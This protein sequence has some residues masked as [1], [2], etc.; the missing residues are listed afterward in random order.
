VSEAK[1]TPASAEGL[2]PPRYQR[3]AW[4]L[5]VYFIPQFLINAF[6]FRSFFI[7]EVTVFPSGLFQPFYRYIPDISLGAAGDSFSILGLCVYLIHLVLTLVVAKKKTFRALLI[8]LVLL[9]LY[10]QTVQILVG[11]FG[12]FLPPFVAQTAPSSS[13]SSI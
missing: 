4:W 13:Q 11:R 6:Y 1:A 12:Y 8:I 7:F 9:V 10:N 2:A 5:A 3:I